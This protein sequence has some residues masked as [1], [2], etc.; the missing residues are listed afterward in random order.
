MKTRIALL[1]TALALAAGLVSSPGATAGEKRTDT[2]DWNYRACDGGYAINGGWAWVCVKA[3][4]ARQS[5][6]V[7]T[8]TSRVHIY[9]FSTEER[10]KVDSTRHDC[11]YSNGW[12]SDT[13]V[14]N[15]TLQVTAWNPVDNYGVIKWQKFTDLNQSDEPTPCDQIWSGLDVHANT[16]ET[17]VLF[18]YK[19]RLNNVPDREGVIGFRLWHNGFGDFWDCY[20]NAVDEVCDRS[21]A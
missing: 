9:A 14:V 17:R 11:T 5:D 8:V 21:L 12:E 4:I 6:G 2:S 10:H 15:K 7:G 18:N 19:M 3:V 1:I 16:I 13:A 20:N